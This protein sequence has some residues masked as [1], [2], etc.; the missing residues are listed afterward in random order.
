MGGWTSCPSN[1]GLPFLGTPLPVTMWTRSERILILA[2]VLWMLI[3]LAVTIAGFTESTVLSLHLPPSLELFILACLKYGDPIS[4]FLAAINTH[5]LAC[6]TWGR[7][8]A[9]KWAAIILIGSAV[10]ETI[11]TLTGWPFGPYH[12]T[13]NFGPRLGDVLPLTIPLSWLVLITN[14]LLLVRYHTHLNPRFE[15]GLIAFGVTLM[16]W[17]MEPFAVHIKAYW[18]WDTPN[19]P[20]QNYVTWFTLTFILVRRFA[21]PNRATQPND[22]RSPII[23]SMMLS[24]FVTARIVSRI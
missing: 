14:V 16:D 21:P 18:Y 24:L 2:Y 1:I 7:F 22:S 20:W 9:R 15:A 4:I 8:T 19:I 3:G 13:D 10:T 12:Y 23:L 17:V 5:W 6:R 11:G